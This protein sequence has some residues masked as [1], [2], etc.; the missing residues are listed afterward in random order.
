MV[1]A[2]RGP[3]TGRTWTML[4]KSPAQAGTTGPAAQQAQ[5]GPVGPGPHAR[6]AAAVPAVGSHAQPQAASLAAQPGRDDPAAGDL[7][8][9]ELA[10]PRSSAA[11]HADERDD[12]GEHEEAGRKAQGDN[13]ETVTENPVANK[14]GTEEQGVEFWAKAGPEQ[15]VG[16]GRPQ[17][18]PAAIASAG[19]RMPKPIERSIERPFERYSPTAASPTAKGRSRSRGPTATARSRTTSP[20]RHGASAQRKRRASRS[21]SPGGCS[22]SLAQY[23]LHCGWQVEKSLGVVRW[24]AAAS[25]ILG[26]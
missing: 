5:G 6:D 9:A 2:L 24:W 22:H 23:D 11:G 16:E 18:G 20:A 19:R 8:P 7:G 25:C 21:K 14:D 1:R 4:I 13:Q 3:S 17:Q 26:W 15:E 12:Q 10:S